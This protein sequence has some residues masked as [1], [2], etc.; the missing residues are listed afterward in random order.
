MR[1][2]YGGSVNPHNIAALMAEEDID[3]ALVGGASLEAET[4]AHCTLWEERGVIAILIVT[5]HIIV[6]LALILI[7]LLQV[8][9]GGSLGAAFGGGGSSQTL[10]G[11]R[12]PATFLSQ[13]TA[14]AA[15][16]FMV[17]SLGLAY[18][19]SNARHGSTITNQVPLQKVSV[20]DATDGQPSGADA[21]DG[22]CTYPD[23]AKRGQ[24]SCPGAKAATIELSS[25][26]RAVQ[27]SLTSPWTVANLYCQQPLATR[28]LPKWWNW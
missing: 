14:V 7:V 21:A 3:G 9:K 11:S 1:L 17:T 28:S 8:G 23:A 24:Q 25:C 18:L 26:S 15:A 4:F 5:V 12:G 6:A 20:A 16:L 19:S 2:Q 10:F 27:K 13:L 22:K